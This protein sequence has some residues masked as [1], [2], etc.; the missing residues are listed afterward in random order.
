MFGRF[1]SKFIII[2]IYLCKARTAA[3]NWSMIALRILFPLHNKKK[4]PIWKEGEKKQLAMLQRL[5][6]KFDTKQ[7][8]FKL[9]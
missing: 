1:S 6:N 2:R 4:M 9:N 3:E 5:V 7:A 8:K